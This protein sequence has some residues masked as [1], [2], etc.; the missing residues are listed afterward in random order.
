MA[1]Y[2]IKLCWSLGY[3][4]IEG[5]EQADI[6]AKLGA[7]EGPLDLDLVPTAAGLKK[8]VKR[9]IKELAEDWLENEDTNVPSSFKAA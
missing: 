2:D 9:Q 3:C 7:K 6:Q 4:N 5:N 8:D 1:T